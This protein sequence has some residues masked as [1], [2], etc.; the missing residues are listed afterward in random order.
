MQITNPSK[1]IRYLQIH[2][3]PPD[4]FPEWSEEQRELWM[5]GEREKYPTVVIDAEFNGEIELPTPGYS[6]GVT[7]NIPIK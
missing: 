1:S 2:S 4:S 7:F 3:Q 5:K 6:T